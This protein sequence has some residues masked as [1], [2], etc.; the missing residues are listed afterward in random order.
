MQE[1]ASSVY[2]IIS[3]AGHSK[4]GEETIEW[5]QGDTISVPSWYKYQHFANK[6]ETVYLYRFH[7]KPMLTA[8]GFYRAAGQDTE[9]LVSD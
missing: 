6:E 5:K 8:L 2:H 9:Q 3:G 1:T 7:D 4:I